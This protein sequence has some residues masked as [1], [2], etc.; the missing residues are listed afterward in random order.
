MCDE[1][2]DD[3]DMESV[4]LP[5]NWTC[6]VRHAFLN[7]VGIVR[8]AMLAGQEFLI[9]EGDVADAHIHRL[10]TEEVTATLDHIIQAEQ[11]K[12]KHLIVD[13]GRGVASA[14][15]VANSGCPDSS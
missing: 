8:V 13:Q 10:E 15:F 9:H 6:M 12:P 14:A 1:F 3:D 4:P 7:V 2:L 11:A 5:K